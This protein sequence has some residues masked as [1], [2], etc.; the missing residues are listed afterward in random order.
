MTERAERLGQNPATVWLTGLPGS[1][2]TT[3]AYALERRLFDRGCFAHVLD[4]E[5]MRAHLSDDLDFSAAGR[6]ENIR[7]VAYVARLANDLGLITIAAF[8]SPYAAIRESARN[9]IGS[10]RF[11]E[12][13][14]NTPLEI[15]ESRDTKGMY[16]RARCGDISDFTGVTAPYEPPEHPDCILPTQDL[17]VDES[18][19]S[20]IRELER[21]NVIKEQ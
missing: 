4:G 17:S 6:R 12:V 3:I 9:I 20:I 1:G 2:K 7:R 13:Y 11:I 5:N 19:D 21:R 18:V 10:E 8:V 15:C 14:L 16:E